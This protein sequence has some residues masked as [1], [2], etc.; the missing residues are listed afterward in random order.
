MGIADVD[1]T[2]PANRMIFD[3]RRDMAL[4]RRFRQNIEPVMAE[5]GLSEAERQAFRGVDLRALALLGVHPYFLPQVSRMF[6]GGAYNVNDSRAAQLYAK[7][8]VDA[9]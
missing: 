2:L 9:G 8:I 3:L 1:R 4:F 6:E 5:Y 7:N